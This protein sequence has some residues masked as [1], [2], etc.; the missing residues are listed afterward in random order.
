VND[1]TKP[2][3][4]QRR[5]RRVRHQLRVDVIDRRGSRRA[6]ASDVARHGLFVTITDPPAERHLVQVVLHLP[7]GPLHAAATVARTLPSRGVGLDL[8]ALS[9]EAKGRWD[10]FVALAQQQGSMPSLVPSASTSTTRSA[11]Q[12]PT[13]L[14]RLLSIERLREYFRNHVA[15]GG[16]I[17]FTPLLPPQGATVELIVVHPRTQAEYSLLGRIQRVVSTPPKHLELVFLDVQLERFTRFIEDGI[18]HE[19]VAA[20]ASPITATLEHGGDRHVDLVDIDVD[21]D[22]DFEI[23][24]D[25]GDAFMQEEPVQWERRYDPSRDIAQQRTDAGQLSLPAPWSSAPLGTVDDSDESDALVIDETLAAADPGLRPLMLRVSCANSACDAATYV[26]ELG[27]CGGAL[28]LFADHVPFWSPASARIVSVPRLV[29]SEARRSRFAAYIAKGGS[30]GD[31]VTLASLLAAADLAE[32]P[33]HPV[34]AEPLRSSRAI[35]RVAFAVARHAVAGA[36]ATTKVRCVACGG[37]LLLS[38]VDDTNAANH[39]R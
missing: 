26:V 28:G 7:D 18:D 8:F 16:T 36:P 14:V 30:L 31:V 5:S 38:R 29:P 23:E 6:T 37:Q 24:I 9:A 19:V 32:A 39:H 10:A 17:L 13:F 20:A 11:S 25:E 21:F 4:E 33:R 1:T 2:R 3:H 35:V 34:T 15:V 27:P 12:R 22:F